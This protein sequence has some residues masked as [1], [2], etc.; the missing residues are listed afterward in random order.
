VRETED[1]SDDGDNGGGSGKFTE[2]KGKRLW[3][4]KNRR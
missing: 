1:Y 4:K 2:M 3:K